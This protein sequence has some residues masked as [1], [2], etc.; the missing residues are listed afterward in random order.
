MYQ[1]PDMYLLFV[2]FIL[3]MNFGDL[4]HQHN[5]EEKKTIRNIENYSQKLTNA[6]LA[7]D[8]NNI[9]L[10]NNLLPNLFL[11]LYPVLPIRETLWAS[12]KCAMMVGARVRV[13]VRVRVPG[14]SVPCQLPVSLPPATS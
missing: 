3:T 12:V 10:Q 8:F 5:Q 14:P 1:E 4:L 11:Y 9:F 13:R 7:I 6:K 2:H